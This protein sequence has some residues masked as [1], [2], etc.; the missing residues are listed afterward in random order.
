M[1]TKLQF[2]RRFLIETVNGQLKNIGQIAHSHYHSEGSLRIKVVVCGLIQYSHQEKKSE[3]NWN[4][5][6]TQMFLYMNE[7]HL[8]IAA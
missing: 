3:L 8:A 2:S 7:K 4:E 1:K 5:E 6:E